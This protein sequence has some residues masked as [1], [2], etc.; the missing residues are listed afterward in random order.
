MRDF[1]VLARKAASQHGLLTTEQLRTFGVSWRTV[2]RMVADGRLHRRGRGV[3]AVGGSPASWH[4]DLAAAVFS[5]LGL[6]VAS[7]RS[8]LRLW[9]LRSIDDELEVTI[10]D[11]R[12]ADR[13]GVTIHRSVDLQAQDRTILYGLPVTTAA[14]TLTDAGLIFP[15]AEVRRLV[16]QALILKIVSRAEL[17][18][19]RRRVSEHGRN[20]IGALEAALA[21]LPDERGADSEPELELRA[22]L[23]AVNMESP[24]AQFRVRT[25]LRTYCID[26]AYPHQKLALEY[27]GFEAHTTREAFERDRQRQNDLQL[28]GWRFLRY[29]WTDLRNRS[30]DVVREVKTALTR[31]L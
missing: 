14:R 5:L 23:Q 11:H 25:R 16:A 9:G 13:A 8:A 15:K 26:L 22:I 4:Q 19:L 29:T 31:D 24:V 3:V 7:H 27:D 20:G 17:W 1:E 12:R 10:P 21:S 30:Q 28:I 2:D 18:S 6:A